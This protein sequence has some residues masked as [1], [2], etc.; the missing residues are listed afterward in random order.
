[1][2][3]I[4]QSELAPLGIKVTLQEVNGAQENTLQSTSQ[5]QMSFLY[6]TT[7]I[8]DPDE[9]MTFAAVGGSG[10]QGTHAEFTNYNNPQ[11]NS[12]VNKAEGVFSQAARIKIYDQ[13]QLILAQDPP[14][15]Y[16]FYQPFAYSFTSKLHGFSVY[17]T[18]NYHFEN[19]W[20]SK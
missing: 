16:L 6:D 9:L 11:V 1:M 14:M 19:A 18:G 17:P 2:G 3:Q 10:A 4:V 5:F 20:L 8:I 13:I 7:D 15:A 12:L